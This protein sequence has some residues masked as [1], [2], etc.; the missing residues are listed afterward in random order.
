MIRDPWPEMKIEGCNIVDIGFA[1]HEFDLV[2]VVC[3]KPGYV[4]T[5]DFTYNTAFLL[6]VCSITCV[7]SCHYS[8]FSQHGE[9]SNVILSLRELSTGA[10]HPLARNPDIVVDPVEDHQLLQGK[11]SIML[12][13]VGPRLLLLLTW[14]RSLQR[15]RQ[16]E[17][18]KLFLFNWWEGTKVVVRSHYI[19]KK[20]Y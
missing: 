9:Q 10:P 18:D 17:Q 5:C 20:S 15:V 6:C 14:H 11:L 2:A 16:R 8:T 12:E 3:V 13:I 1:L 7:T 4:H 19:P